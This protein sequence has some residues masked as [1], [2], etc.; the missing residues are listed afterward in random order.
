MSRPA[1]GHRPRPIRPRPDL[2]ALATT[3][4]LALLAPVLRAEHRVNAQD[5]PAPMA[6]ASVAPGEAVVVGQ[7][8]T[9][10]IEVL[11]PTFFRGAPAYDALE[12]PGA[13]A[14]FN[15]RGTNFTERIEGRTWAGQRRSYTIY[16]N[17]VGR[18]EV[19]PIPVEVRYGVGSR[20]VVDTAYAA[21]V[22]FDAVIPEAARGLPV[23]IAAAELRLV[24]SVE[25]APD[26]IRVGEAF[27][28][29]VTTEVDGTL[30]MVVPPL[31][32]DSVEG[33]AVYPAPPRLED[34][35]GE[36]GTAVLGRRVESAS[37]VATAEG[38]YT[39][40]PVRVDWWDWT[41]GRLRRAEAPGLAF[42]VVA[43]PDLAAEIEL[44]PDSLDVEEASAGPGATG[45]DER[46]RRWLTGLAI[47]AGLAYVGYRLI[48]PR[49]PPWRARTRA[50]RRARAESEA[51]YFRRL[52]AAVRSND[53][54]ASANA[55]AAWLD[56]LDPIGGTGTAGELVDAAQ[57]PALGTE[58]RRLDEVLYGAGSSDASSWSGAALA[59]Q[60]KSAR[61]RVLHRPAAS[62]LA[63]PSTLGPLNP[64]GS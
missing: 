60:L 27:T 45:V 56:R 31:A 23:F 42:E 48:G 64:R 12:L 8:V 25:P 21:P 28:R 1:R 46:L 16:P 57:D 44:P 9:V 14:F 17:R 30:S 52:Q 33:L 6:R 18:Y 50:R 5:E 10:G 4:V 26:T 47:I 22:R 13:I 36:R 51:A 39:L 58:L 41:T 32:F 61:R 2:P 53:P 29:V 63:D 15:E 3:V 40:P 49:I 59:G 54:R 55:L 24:Q 34:T 37:Y 7:P 19:G 43:N 20:V 35:G 38:S 11:V 62:G